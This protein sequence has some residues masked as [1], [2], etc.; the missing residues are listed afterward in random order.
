M[1]F[2]N[3]ETANTY[4]QVAGKSKLRLDTLGAGIQET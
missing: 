4:N 1:V 3:E 2:R